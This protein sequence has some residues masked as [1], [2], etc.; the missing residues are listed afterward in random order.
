MI[1]K[2]VA[3]DRG[4]VGYRVYMVCVSYVSEGWFFFYINK[5]EGASTVKKL[6]QVN[7]R[8]ILKARGH[9]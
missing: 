4:Q 5:C 2:G 7:S 3:M 8:F 6:C 1:G 9:Y